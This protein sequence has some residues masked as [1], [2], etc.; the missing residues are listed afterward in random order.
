M[1]STYNTKAYEILKN[2]LLQGKINWAIVH[3]LPASFDEISGFEISRFEKRG[4]R[5]PFE[6][7]SA[8]LNI[9][10]SKQ[11]EF[12]K[13]FKDLL[14]ETRSDITALA[15]MFIV[16]WSLSCRD[17]SKA[18][19]LYYY[20]KI[21][22]TEYLRVY[23]FL[24][25]SLNREYYAYHHYQKLDSISS[26]EKWLDVFHTAQYFSTNN[27]PV[28]AVTRLVRSERNRKIDYQYVTPMKPILRSVL[29]EWYNFEIN[30]HK[31]F[32]INTINSS[33]QET[34]FIAA[35]ILDDMSKEAKP[36]K[37]LD[38]DIIELLVTRY[39]SQVGSCIFLHVYGISY[40]NRHDNNVY[41]R[42][43]NKLKLIFLHVVCNPK[44]AGWQESL[45]FPHGYVAFF[46]W[47]RIHGTENIPNDV[48][49]LLKDKLILDLGHVQK[50]SATIIADSNK[51]IF[52][53][54]NYIKS[55]YQNTLPYL[56]WLLLGLN[57]EQ[58]RKFQ[59]ILLNVKP[60]FYGGFASK[61]FAKEFVEFILLVLTSITQLNSID[62]SQKLILRKLLDIVC[63]SVIVP[64]IHLTERKNE[65]WD[66][67]AN[68][69]T[70][71]Y[72]V[73]LALLNIR[74]QAVKKSIYEQDFKDFFNYLNSIKVTQWPYE[75]IPD[76]IRYYKFKSL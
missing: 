38:T 21:V 60:L 30:A 56:L 18:S 34:A 1:T 20:K 55:D 7:G 50:K 12:F 61:T 68:G 36:P 27:D 9:K 41:K 67:L 17:D 37:W 26:V 75:R 16:Y 2:A 25:N 24:I 52:A 72:G 28:I 65:V 49:Y 5:S 51:N 31:D 43:K 70:L 71:F 73:T 66:P 10:D 23:Q 33:L 76:L 54:Y 15:N 14:V 29:I 53:S 19:I 3:E 4:D 35:T 45:E 69:E 8:Y 57:D 42:L 62:E 39:W 22:G 13:L 48:E 32:F 6:F 59:S 11:K 63:K 44:L 40:R 46:S 47:V 74:L 64:Y 58:L